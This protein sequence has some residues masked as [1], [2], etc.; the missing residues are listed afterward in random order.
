MPSPEEQYPLLAAQA[1]TDP[2]SAL[3]LKLHAILDEA[4]SGTS[5]TRVDLSASSQPAN[6]RS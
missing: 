1:A 5:Q 6:Q 4:L 3:L 2:E